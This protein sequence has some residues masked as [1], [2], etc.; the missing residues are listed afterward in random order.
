M[1]NRIVIKMAQSMLKDQDLP[2]SLYAKAE[3][4]TICILNCSYIKVLNFNINTSLDACLGKKLAH[5]RVSGYECYAH[6]L[7]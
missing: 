1:Q 3:N 2:S 7:D 6:I 5:F 4:I